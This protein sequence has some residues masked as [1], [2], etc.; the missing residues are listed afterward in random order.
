[1]ETTTHKIEFISQGFL[2][3]GVLHLPQAGQPPLVVGSHGL[4]GSKESAKQKVLST[5]LVKNNIAFFRFDHRGCGKSQGDFITDTSL[6]KRTADFINA[7]QHVL[8]LGKTS[9][10]LAIFGSSL[11]G[12]T[13]INAWNTLLQMDVRLCGAVLCSAPAKSRTVEKIPTGANNGRPAL[14]LSFFKKNL[15]FNITK[16][17]V[18]LS[19]VL[20][21]HGDADEVVPVSNAHDIYTLAKEPKRL[22]IHENG[23]HQMTSKKD[24]AEFEKEAAAWFLHCFSQ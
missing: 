11:G 7:V 21:F 5:L 12:S 10:D 20:I 3:K 8:D 2:L 14:P 19:N 17:A 15:L 4:E 22:I 18:S 16:K 13:C 24:Q 23:D 1:M 6:E 9:R